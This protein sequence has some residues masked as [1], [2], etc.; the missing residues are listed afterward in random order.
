M[1]SKSTTTVPALSLLQLALSDVVLVTYATLQSEIR[2]INNAVAHN[3]A[4]TAASSRSRRHER[5]FPPPTTNLLLVEC[6]PPRCAVF[7][8]SWLLTTHTHMLTLTLA[9]SL[10][11]SCVG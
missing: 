2:Y 7:P 1:G 4:A 9:D 11:A 6:V 5:R 3:E 10:L 8:A